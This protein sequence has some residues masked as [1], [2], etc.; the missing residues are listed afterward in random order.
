MELL[1]AQLNRRNRSNC[2][3]GGK[4]IDVEHPKP[5]SESEM[6][7]LLEE[8]CPSVTCPTCLINLTEASYFEM[9]KNSDL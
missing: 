9:P 1:S 7:H 4:V 8:N 6:N 2:R 3:F 5:D